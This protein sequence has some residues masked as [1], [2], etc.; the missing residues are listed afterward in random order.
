MRL[1]IMGDSHMGGLYNALVGPEVVTTMPPSFPSGVIA[2]GTE[3]VNRS[4]GGETATAALTRVASV[5]AD[6]PYDA[7]IVCYGTNDALHEVIFGVPDLMANTVANVL[8]LVAELETVTPAGKV[9]AAEPVGGRIITADVPPL[10]TV[11]KA[12]DVRKH[13]YTV[14]HGLR[15][16]GHAL[17]LSLPQEPQFF[18]ETDYIHCSPLGYEVLAR[19]VVDFLREQG[20]EC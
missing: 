6:G 8:T 7:A 1:L 3:V 19:R 16:A 11:A 17:S 4:Q 5:V 14:G 20:V 13:A 12:R 15:A 10:V 18:G 9:F 2:A